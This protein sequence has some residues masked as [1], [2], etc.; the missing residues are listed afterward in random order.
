MEVAFS[1]TCYRQRTLGLSYTLCMKI[2]F[3]SLLFCVGCSSGGYQ[4]GSLQYIMQQQEVKMAKSCYKAL[5][6]NPWKETYYN[7]GGV[8]VDERTYCSVV[9]HRLVHARPAAM[10]VR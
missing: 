10:S 3:V 4:P 6:H 2:L 9:A 8:L 5:T 1:A 7:V